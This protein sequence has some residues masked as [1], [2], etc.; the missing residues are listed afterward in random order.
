MG[1]WVSGRRRR[2]SG[3]TRWSRRCGKL[4]HPRQWLGAQWVGLLLG[5]RA[6]HSRQA[7]PEQAQQPW[8]A[9]HGAA[10]D[11]YEAECASMWSKRPSQGEPK[12]LGAQP[13]PR[14]L[15]LAAAG[16]TEGSD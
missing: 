12:P 1:K 11:G 7:R 16:A 3:L 15:E 2:V 5:C 10:K 6:A 9:K 8:V 14:V 4:E 13:L